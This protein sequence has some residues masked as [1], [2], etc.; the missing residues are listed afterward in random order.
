M[1]DIDEDL[2][3]FDGEWADIPFSERANF[4]KLPDGKYQAEIEEAR[5]EHSKA[6]NLQLTFI[7]RILS[8][9]FAGST[10]GKFTRLDRPNQ[11]DDKGD[12]KP[13]AGRSIAKNDMHLLG[14]DVGKLSDLPLTTEMVIG[15]KV[16]ISIQRKTIKDIE[17]TNTYLNKV[18]DTAAAE[19]NYLDNP[20]D[21]PW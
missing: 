8:G 15:T 16:E 9:D 11:Y 20:D 17:Y 3:G 13:D 21:Q 14:Q 12:E 10:H 6:G 19:N 7:F 18:L 4:G 5:V 2:K 1:T